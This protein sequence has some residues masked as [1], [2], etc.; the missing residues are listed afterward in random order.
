M[1]LKA[2][3]QFRNK[4]FHNTKIPLNRIYNKTEKKNNSERHDLFKIHE[5]F[6]N[7]QDTAIRDKSTWAFIM[8]KNNF[9]DLFYSKLESPDDFLYDNEYT[10][11]YIIE[12]T[13][14]KN[15]I[16]NNLYMNKE[17]LSKI[18]IPAYLTKKY[19]K[20][21]RLILNK[22][23]RYEYLNDS[24]GLIITNYN[25]YCTFLDFIPKY[26]K[27]NNYYVI[28]CDSLKNY[29]TLYLRTPNKSIIETID[30]YPDNND[31]FKLSVGTIK[32]IKKFYDTFEEAV[33]DIKTGEIKNTKSIKIIIDH[34][35]YRVRE[36]VE[37][38]VS[39]FNG[40]PITVTTRT[41]S[42]EFVNITKDPTYDAKYENS[43]LID[44][45]NYFK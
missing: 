4:L 11:N 41:L 27:D 33:F 10:N 37:Q 34:V 24:S 38:G 3:N 6:P 17:R 28:Y 29:D 31:I 32:K 40:K 14:D 30:N 19:I 20:D 5:C 8:S 18:K 35:Q 2:N 23:I 12:I 7:F 16:E 45:E 44:R 1:Q 36:K 39:P 43:N 22:K 15:N 42:E 25:L 26:Y 21:N 9:I 13:N